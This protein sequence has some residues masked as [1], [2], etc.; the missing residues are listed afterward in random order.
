MRLEYGDPSTNLPERPAFRVGVRDIEEKLRAKLKALKRV[1]TKADARKVAT[2]A[3]DRLRGAYL[4]YHGP[5]LSERQR[6]RKEG[7]GYADD[8]LVGAQGPKLVGHIHAYVD[9]EEV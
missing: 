7:T 8:E 5:G 9:G 6:R 4:R 2:W 3:R 1:P